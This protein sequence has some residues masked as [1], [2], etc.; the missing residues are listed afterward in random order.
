MKRQKFLEEFLKLY[1]VEK[2]EYK[3]VDDDKII[4]TAVYDTNDSEEKQEF[5]WHMSEEKLP[6]E[7]TL[8]LIQTINENGWCD[9]DKITVSAKELFQKLKWNDEKLF[10]EAFA[11]L[12]DVEIKMLD[13]G[14]ETDSFFVHK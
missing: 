14:K 10:N 12:F 3:Q 7:S 11:E 5:C 4:G 6:S 13:N 2:V 8:K 1:R 9:I